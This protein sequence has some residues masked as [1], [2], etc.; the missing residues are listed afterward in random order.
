MKAGE[1][2]ETERSTRATPVDA[3]LV[4]ATL[5]GRREAFGELVERYQRRAT[6]VA[7]RLL[8][9]L[10]DAL[11][12]CQESFVRAFRKLESLEDPDRFGPWLLR[13]V[14]NLALNFRRSRGPRLSFTDCLVGTDES[15]EE[16]VADSPHSEDRP[17]LR[18]AGDEL[19]ARIQEGM[20]QLSPQQRAA[21][22]LF[23][24]E[25]LPQKDVA[26]ILNCS[27]EAVKWHVF[28][29]RKKMKEFLA[30]YF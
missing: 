20:A 27:V 11:E 12:V 4:R 23:S 6:S 19:R 1:H 10:H 14:T 8:G 25:Q 22:V 13:I 9:D 16:R 29:G 26:R 5:A 18:L 21:L 7:Y 2:V 30:D 28:Q 3:D 24:V 17:G 15:R